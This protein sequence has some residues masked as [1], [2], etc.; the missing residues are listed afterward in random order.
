MIPET[1]RNANSELSE[2]R[3][4]TSNGEANNHIAYHGHKSYLDSCCSMPNL[5]WQTAFNDWFLDA[6]T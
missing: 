3:V 6:P 4:V 1:G 5:Q 2:H